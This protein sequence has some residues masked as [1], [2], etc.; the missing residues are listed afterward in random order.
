MHKELIRFHIPM[1]D[2]ADLLSTG[3][4]KVQQIFST[5]AATDHS[6]KNR[7]WYRITTNTVNMVVSQGPPMDRRKS[8]QRGSA[9]VGDANKGRRVK[10]A[11][12]GK[13]AFLQGHRA[14]FG[15]FE[16]FLAFLFIA[17][18]NPYLCYKFQ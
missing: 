6:R 13:L 9:L 7:T 15:H 11:Q 12:C 16:G 2:A 8:C 18:W 10:Q 17:S 1:H 5:M 4:R 14:K 3:P